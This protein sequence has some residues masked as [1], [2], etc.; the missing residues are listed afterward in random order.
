MATWP[1]ATPAHAP[2]GARFTAVKTLSKGRRRL[3]TRQL[4]AAFTEDQR[5]PAALVGQNSQQPIATRIVELFQ[6]LGDPLVAAPDV[7]G[8][9][10]DSP[11]SMTW[12]AA[13]DQLV[14]A[15][16]LE[17]DDRT[18]RPFDPKDVVLFR[19]RERRRVRPPQARRSPSGPH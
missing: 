18:Q 1:Q 12:T 15:E 17:M 9:S 5:A 14:A 13:L 10:A 4:K 2:C 3:W 8:C 16:S 6:T 7:R 19:R 11:L